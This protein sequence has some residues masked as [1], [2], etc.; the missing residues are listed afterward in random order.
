MTA[1]PDHGV[2]VTQYGIQAPDSD[3]VLIVTT[4]R[5]EAQH[6]LAWI[7]HGRIVCRTITYGDWLSER[8]HRLD[9]TIYR[10]GHPVAEPG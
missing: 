7:Q 4:D 5:E 6:A 2:S 3:T 1:S 8:D 9:E 10:P